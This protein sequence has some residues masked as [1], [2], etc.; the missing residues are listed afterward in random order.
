MTSKEYNS[1]SYKRDNISTG[2]SRLPWFEDSL[3]TGLESVCS[4]FDNVYFAKSL[5]IIT[6]QNVLYRH[7]NKGDW[8]SKLWFVTLVLSIRRCLRQ[9]FRILQDRVK[10][11]KE[12]KSM[13]KSETGLVKDVLKEKLSTM[14]QKSSL[15]IKA[16]MFEVLQN[17]LY[18]IIVAV[19]VFKIRLP[20]RW[21]RV[22][23]PIS[24]FVTVLRLVAFGT[25]SS[26]DI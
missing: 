11:K 3:I 10:L 19:D 1:S 22:L 21:R 6:E 13:G 18:L 16:I 24:N 25:S 2:D 4:F 26:L 8:G 7:L 23:E 9:L 20:R 14:L 5:G 12:L 17:T 15:M